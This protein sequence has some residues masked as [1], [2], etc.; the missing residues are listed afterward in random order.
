MIENNIN[1]TGIS[2]IT[3]FKSIDGKIIMDSNFPQIMFDL[4]NIGI[5]PVIHGDVIIDSVKN[6]S[7]LSGDVVMTK[8]SEYFTPEKVFFITNV[9]GIY[10]FPPSN[11]ELEIENLIKE[12]S[13]D[14][15]GNIDLK[16]NLSYNDVTKGILGKIENAVQIAKLGVEVYISKCGDL[17]TEKLLNDEKLEKI[18]RFTKIFVNST[19]KNSKLGNF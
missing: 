14:E 2:C 5:V 19:K 4:M 1:A 16:S 9:H 11:E 10:L 13:V 12:I 15:I 6:C 17:T 18:D 7:I 8:L 3:S